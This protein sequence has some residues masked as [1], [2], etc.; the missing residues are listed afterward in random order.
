MLARYAARLESIFVGRHE[1]LET[2]RELWNA[3]LKPQEH[4]VYVLL[5]APGV[6]KTRL[7]QQ[8]GEEIEKLGEG[9]YFHYSCDG[10]LIKTSDLHKQLI[11]HLNE[12]L[13]TRSRF[14]IEY[15][16]ANYHN[17]EEK[18]IRIQQFEQ[19]KSLLQRLTNQHEDIITLHEVV[20]AFQ[21]LTHIVPL[22]FVADEIQEFQKVI[23]QVDEPSLISREVTEET[24]LHYFTRLLKSFLRSR[25]LIILSGT[26]YHI[27]SQIGTKI[28]SPIAQK[29]QQ[30]L[31]KNFTVQEIEE[32]VEQVREKFIEPRSPKRKDATRENLLE[33]YARFL[34][35]FSGGHPRTVTL[36]T[37]WFLTLYSQSIGRDYTFE[38]FVNDLFSKVEA[39][40]KQRILTTEKQEHI[41]SLQANKYFTIVKEWITDQ[42]T[43]GFS[44]GS[45]P[46]LD[47]SLETREQVE[48]LIYQ[49]MTVGIIVKNGWDQYH[50]ASYFHLLAFLEC[51]TG[52]HEQ[53]LYQILTNKFFKLM[54]GSHAGFGYTFEHVLISAF[55]IK[56]QLWATRPK[57]AT[58][59]ELV[60]VK[61]PISLSKIT[62]VKEIAGEIDWNSLKL[63]EGIL[64]HVPHASSI[65]MFVFY[66]NKL[67]LIQAT[68]TLKHQAEK[69]KEISR[70][71][72][73]LKSKF[74][75]FEVRGWFI[76]LFPVSDDMIK[77]ESKHVIITSGK[78]LE[79]ILG[80]SILKRLMSVKRSLLAGES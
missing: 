35:S 40:F 33:Y 21:R 53:F 9:L 44:L 43:M 14:V 51:L 22:F 27:L 52:E 80:K 18:Q 8:F 42:A 25:I 34:H 15:M 62:R 20:T 39:D 66:D 60:K 55:L 28:G 29:V 65:D 75:N 73:E 7:L 5:N 72:M 59:G 24:A 71:I 48:D 69:I 76:S 77:N 74:R 12:Y 78:D 58:M 50:L 46:V 6:G 31:I 26:Q 61:S 56:G 3:T 2:L 11:E 19:L 67:I 45:G 79:P 36:I 47:F 23:L 16:D 13:I 54:C 17:Q 70:K 63:E 64:Y 32:Y 1:E 10:S 41:R 57:T 37:Q 30:I 49:L 68:T 4:R 38:E